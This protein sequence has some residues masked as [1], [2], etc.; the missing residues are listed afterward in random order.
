M[1]TIRRH[2]LVAYF[3]LAV[4]IAL[5]AMT[6]RMA[7]P[8]ALPAALK[9]MFAKN[10]KADIF[11]A[12]SYSIEHPSLWHALLFPFAPTLA[13]FVIISTA[14]GWKG[15]KEWFSRALP[16]RLGVSTVDA[17]SVWLLF[18]AVFLAF[19]AFSLIQ[20]LL[21]GEPE[22]ATQTVSRFGPT[23][24]LAI[25]GFAVAPFLSPGPILEEMGWRGFALPMLLR[26]F[27]PVMAS[28]VLG[29]M[30]AAWHLPREILPL[31]SG[32]SEAWMPFFVKQL[33]LFPGSIA[34]SIIATFLFFRLGGSAW[35]GVLAHAFHNELAV[36]VFRAQEPFINL[37]GVQLRGLELIEIGLAVVLLLLA[38]PEL[39]RSRS[40]AGNPGPM[41]AKGDA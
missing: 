40:D 20:S 22:L 15:L 21:S 4:L 8:T 25:L 37:G 33:N 31:T 29:T 30:W 17:L 35:G 1:G 34:T 26:R 16:W 38:G 10:L 19:V 12:V 18:L 6:I 39:G 32:G 28:I 5:A 14:F 36:N 41:A 11:S 2:P 7:D 9:D 3:V 27:S 24:S 23:A 13:A